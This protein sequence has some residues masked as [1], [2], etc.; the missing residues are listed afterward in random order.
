MSESND[1]EMTM[2]ELVEQ[3]LRR[4]AELNTERRTWEAHW[5]SLADYVMPRK[6]EITAQGGVPGSGADALLFDSTAV[7]ANMVLANG[8]LANMTPLEGRWFSFDP[9]PYLKGV[10]A[11]EQYYRQCTET[12]QV[13]LARSNFYS[14]IHE[15]YLDRGGFGTAAIFCEEGLRQVLNFRKLD[16]RWI[17]R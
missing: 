10:D 2:S 11:V 7:R 14:E 9:P 13:E 4:E 16:V 17:F 3:V 12:A 1:S 5:Q 6:A 8:Q 15:L